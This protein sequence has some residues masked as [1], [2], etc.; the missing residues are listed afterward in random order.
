MEVANQYVSLKHHVDGHPSQSD[1][2][3]AAATLQAAPGSNEVIVK[4]LFLSIDPYQLNR[5]KRCSSSHTSVPAASQ[6]EPG[7]ARVAWPLLVAQVTRFRRLVS[8]HDFAP[9]VAEDRCVRGGEGCGL[10][11]GGVGGGRC[12]G[13]IAGVGAVHGGPAGDRLDESGREGSPT[14]VLRQ[15]FG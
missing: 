7:Q 9:L 10:G 15:R 4:N 5:M 3:F 1:F 11:E 14:F 13:R 12:G 6:I 8:A 2:E